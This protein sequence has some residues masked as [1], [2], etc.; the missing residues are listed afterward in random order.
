MSLNETPLGRLINHLH[1]LF[2]EHLE[3]HPLNDY[4]ELNAL[5]D[6]RNLVVQSV[7]SFLNEPAIK[8]KYG[9]PIDSTGLVSFS[10]NDEPVNPNNSWI[11]IPSDEDE[12]RPAGI[13]N[14]EFREF[15]EK[16]DELLRDVDMDPVKLR[17]KVASLFRKAFLKPAVNKPFRAGTYIRLGGAG[18]VPCEICGENRVVDTCHIIPRR[19]QGSGRI[20]NILYLCPTHHRLFDTCMLSKE[21]WERVDWPRKARKSWIYAEKVLRVAHG[22]FWDKV[23][24]G[25]YKKQT[26]EEMDVYYLRRLYRE[27]QK[28][29][30]EAE[31]ASMA[32]IIEG[33]PRKALTLICDIPGIMKLAGM[34][35]PVIAE[36]AG[37]LQK[38]IYKRFN[39]KKKENIACLLYTLDKEG[40]I[41]RE[42]AGSSYRITLEKSPVEVMAALR[43][44]PFE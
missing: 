22:Q 15:E 5:L 17:V 26:T 42:K 44:N 6:V 1:N 41:I 38:D 14:E 20:D 10:H 28:D 36:N 31:P 33:P 34:V 23:E 9:V 3:K 16:L 2:D 37:I 13:T 21:E 30:E 29:I 18:Q 25:I 32:D 43:G 40:L 35:L 11:P 8:K 12:T 27:N 24:Q 19:V 7:E 39:S 4:R